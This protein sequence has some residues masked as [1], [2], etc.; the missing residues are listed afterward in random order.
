MAGS[1][2]ELVR[3]EVECPMKLTNA[4]LSWTGH[5]ISQTLPSSVPLAGIV[6]LLL[7]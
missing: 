2:G 3:H 5:V 7:S 6:L 1:A 4:P